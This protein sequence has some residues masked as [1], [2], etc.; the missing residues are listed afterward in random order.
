MEEKSKTKVIDLCESCQHSWIV[1]GPDFK[2]KR[3]M[4]SGNWLGINVITDCNRYLKEGAKGKVTFH[5]PTFVDYEKEMLKEEKDELVPVEAVGI[6]NL[7]YC[8][9]HRTIVLPYNGEMPC[10]MKAELEEYRLEAIEILKM[11]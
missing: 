6:K 7:K 9:K 2:N 11:M 5:D 8:K 4:R 10:C 1:E 3:C